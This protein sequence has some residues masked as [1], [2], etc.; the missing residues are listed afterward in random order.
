MQ[1]VLP[2]MI[3]TTE[4][5]FYEWIMCVYEKLP[6]TDTYVCVQTYSNEPYQ[7]DAHTQ[8][9]KLKNIP[10]ALLKHLRTTMPPP[11]RRVPPLPQS[12]R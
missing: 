1:R 9:S 10:K 2:L 4:I 5:C 3:Q 11:F 12:P 8:P 6:D 7:Q